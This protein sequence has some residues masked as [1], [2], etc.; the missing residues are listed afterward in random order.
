MTTKT[1]TPILT[2]KHLALCAAILAIVAAA[3]AFVGGFN[4][5]SAQTREPA[6]RPAPVETVDDAAEAPE[7]APDHRA[8]ATRPTADSADSTAANDADQADSDGIQGED[9]ASEAAVDEVIDIEPAF[10]GY[11][12]DEFHQCVEAQWS[13][14][15]EPMSEEE[16]EAAVEAVEAQIAEECV[17]LLSDDEQAEYLAQQAY[18]NCQNDIYDAIFANGEEVSEEQYEA[19]HDQALVECLPLLPE[20][21]QAEILAWE[22]YYDCIE[23]QSNHDGPHLEHLLAQRECLNALPEELRADQEMYLNWEICLAENGAYDG[24]WNADGA[25]TVNV[26]AMDLFE[27]LILGDEPATITITSDGSSISIETEGD[28]V[29]F[30]YEAYYEAQDQA[31]ETCADL[32]PYPAEMH[33]DEGMPMPMPIPISAPMARNA[34]GG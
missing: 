26:S 32:D 30:D 3:F 6:T 17:P 24:P 28:V 10:P 8:P 9:A 31:Y 27:E 21:Q 22:A 4:E 12:N 11:G 18:N 29:V 2:I 14:M 20:D 7:E 34:V 33:S 1:T 25:G 23:A 5:A 15:D 13:E 19:A 16:W